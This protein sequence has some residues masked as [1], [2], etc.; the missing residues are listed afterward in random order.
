MRWIDDDQFK[1][2]MESEV[3]PYLA[4]RRETGFDERVPGQPIYFEH[5]RADAP[6]GAIVISH[7]FTESIRKFPE[8]IYYMLQRGYDVWGLDH[9]GHGLSYR[10]GGGTLVVHVDRFEDYV[11][12]LVHL[13]ETR[14][15]P[16]EGDLPLYLYCH[17]MGGCVGAWTIE[18][19]PTLFRKAVLS[20]PMLGLG[21]GKIP[22]PVAYAVASLRSIGAGAAQPLSPVERMPEETYEASASNSPAR[23]DWYYGKKL[24]DP[25]LQ[26]CAASAGWGKN[27][28]AATWRVGKARN[29]QKIQIPVLLFQAGNDAFVENGGQDAFAAKAKSCE[30]VKLPGKRHELY[31]SEGADLRAYWEKIFSFLEG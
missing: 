20:S 1:Q 4:A 18:D 9:R 3:E 30:L 12:D 13:T 29:V 28:I 11:L 5:Y 14:V 23:F 2:C 10:P 22:T 7:G 27:A 6:K 26:T 21:F 31:F 24:A 15:R 17:S 25:K 19:Y 16:A 8:P